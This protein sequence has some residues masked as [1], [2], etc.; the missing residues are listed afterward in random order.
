MARKGW[1]NRT[2]A[3]T[4]TILVWFPLLFPLLL[5]FLHLARGGPFLF[6]Y[7]MPGEFFPLVLLGGILLLVAAVRAG[8]RV[9]LIAWSLG[10]GVTLLGVSL[11]TAQVTG[12]AS[13][14][15]P[16]AGPLFLLVQLAFAVYFGAVVA[17]AVGGLA[18]LRDLWR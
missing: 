11:L 10:V 17:V 2:L 18:L 1:L 4:G 6:D 8:S 12:I 13:G 16:A 14:A 15:A 5:A 7:L 3:A 9:R